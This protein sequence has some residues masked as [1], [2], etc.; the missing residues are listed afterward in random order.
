MWVCELG[1]VAITL[2]DTCVSCR[3]HDRTDLSD[4]GRVLER[5][6]ETRDAGV[7]PRRPTICRPTGSLR[8]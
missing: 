3:I 8:G 6:R 4:A 7:S 2:P 5:A 1:E